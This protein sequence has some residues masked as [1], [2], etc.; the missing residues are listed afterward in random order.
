MGESGGD[1]VSRDFFNI[2]SLFFRDF[3]FSISAS[4][5]AEFWAG[6]VVDGYA[7]DLETFTESSI[8]EGSSVSFSFMAD[9]F[10]NFLA[11]GTGLL[12]FFG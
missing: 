4:R 8:E 5:S 9:E 3:C 7:L 10:V 11:S 1:P 12:D 6:F 2:C